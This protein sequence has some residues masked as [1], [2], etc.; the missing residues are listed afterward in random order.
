MKKFLENEELKIKKTDKEE[1]ELSKI[2]AEM[3]CELEKISDKNGFVN[4][5]NGKYFVNLISKISYK[6]EKFIDEE[7]YNDAFELI[8]HTYYFIKNTFMDGSNG[9][10]QDS[11]YE[12]SSSASKLLYEKKYYQKFLKWTDDIAENN[13]LGDFSDAPLYAFILY[14]HDKESAQKVVKILDECQIK[15]Y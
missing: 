3:K 2:Y 4:Y 1:S 12:L 13:E 10:Y 9:E 14:V 6:I 7:N 8:K 5:Y 11:L 15:Y